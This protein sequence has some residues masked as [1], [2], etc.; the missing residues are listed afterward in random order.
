M[1]RYPSGFDRRSD[2]GWKL[3]KT[4]DMGTIITFLTLLITILILS[5]RMEHRFTVIEMNVKT[6]LDAR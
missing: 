2:S 6:L 4:F 3:S 1:P 5:N